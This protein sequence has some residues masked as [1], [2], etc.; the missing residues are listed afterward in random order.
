MHFDYL[1]SNTIQS[2][3]TQDT[4]PSAKAEKS[5][6]HEQLKYHLNWLKKICM[7]IYEIDQKKNVL[8][9]FGKVITFLFK[10]TDFHL[11]N[12]FLCDF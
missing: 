10:R 8:P 7:K 12:I 2:L 11:Q 9:H 4:F 6:E 1:Q 5:V 3:Q